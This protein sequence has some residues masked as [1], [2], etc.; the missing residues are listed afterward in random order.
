M[1]KIC[2]STI[3]YAVERVFAQENDASVPHM[4]RAGLFRDE[5]DRH[6]AF[7]FCFLIRRRR[8]VQ[9]SER[10]LYTSSASDDV[11]FAPIS[12]SMDGL[13][14]KSFMIWKRIFASLPIMGDV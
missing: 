12:S 4:K 14:S 2:I 10:S 13:I 3:K 11:V 8:F 9:F 6:K 5:R 7:L 1:K